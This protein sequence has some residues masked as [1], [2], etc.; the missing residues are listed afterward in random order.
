VNKNLR[1]TTALKNPINLAL[2][3]P[4]RALP[5][6]K[7]ARRRRRTRTEEKKKMGAQEQRY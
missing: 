6:P 1:R 2:L 7:P 5:C 3:A 4:G